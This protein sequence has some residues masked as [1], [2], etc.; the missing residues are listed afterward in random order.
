MEAVDLSDKQG[1]REDSIEQIVNKARSILRENV[2]SN[3]TGEQL[4]K[5]LNVGYSW[6]RKVFKAYTG[7]GPGQYHIQLKIEKAK[8]LLSDPTRSIKTI[9]YDLHFESSLY[10]SRLFREKTGLNPDKYRRQ[11]FRK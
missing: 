8:I 5:E 2:E 4:A 1:L 6:F 11:Y 10:F 7:M 3:I 9:A